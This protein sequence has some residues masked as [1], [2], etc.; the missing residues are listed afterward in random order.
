M[1]HAAKAAISEEK[2]V[3]LEAMQAISGLIAA[4]ESRAVAYD[5]Q[6]EK[7]FQTYQEEVGK[8]IDKL[9]DH[10]MASGEVCR[11]TFYPSGRHR[12]RQGI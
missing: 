11:C 2:K 1:V 9:E 12:E 10:G 6:L 3:V 5:G 4:F 7:A 8:T